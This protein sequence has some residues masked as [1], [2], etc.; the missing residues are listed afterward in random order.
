[1]QHLEAVRLRVREQKELL[2]GTN[3][4]LKRLRKTLKT[5][6]VIF[7]VHAYMALTA[8]MDNTIQLSWSLSQHA[9]RLQRPVN[10]CQHAD[11]Q[12]SCW[13][14]RWC[15]EADKGKHHNL[16]KKCNKHIILG[17]T[18]QLLAEKAKEQAPVPVPALAPPAVPTPAPAEAQPAPTQ[19]AAPVMQ[20]DPSTAWKLEKME[21]QVL[22]FA[23]S[24]FWMYKGCCCL[25]SL[26]SSCHVYRKHV[27]METALMLACAVLST[28]HGLDC[29]CTCAFLAATVC[30]LSSTTCA[31]STPI[32]HTPL[33]QDNHG[34]SKFLLVLALQLA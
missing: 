23:L 31:G 33:K 14:I 19:A 20:V 7:H 32:K 29:N 25:F 34:L 9:S 22:S 13:N 24:L 11:I 18:L 28:S 30:A 2:A 21:L 3:K 1:M 17:C 15:V 5:Y 8:S 10:I 16:I 26:H 27:T 12:K 4:E 6:E